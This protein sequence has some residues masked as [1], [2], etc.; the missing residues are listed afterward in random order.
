MLPVDRLIGLAVTLPTLAAL[1]AAGAVLR[2]LGLLAEPA[3]PTPPGAL[4]LQ[5]ADGTRIALYPAAALR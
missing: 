3:P 1:A 5:H 2:G 4:V